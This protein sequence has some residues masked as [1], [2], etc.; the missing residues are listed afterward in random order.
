[1]EHRGV[2]YRIIQG[3]KRSDWKWSVLSEAARRK[4]GDHRAGQV[5]RA[6]WKRRQ[7]APPIGSYHRLRWEQLPN[8]ARDR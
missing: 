5:L 7:G 1:M 6:M 2:E 8:G 4:S 3:I